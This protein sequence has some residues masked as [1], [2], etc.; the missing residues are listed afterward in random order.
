[1]TDEVLNL[2]E[3]KPTRAEILAKAR[4]AKAAK[5]IENPNPVSKVPVT[6][7]LE[8]ELWCRAYAYALLSCGINHPKYTNLAVAIADQ[9]VVDFKTKF[10]VKS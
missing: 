2:Q 9:A 8:Q 6:N 10:G 5:A 3:N 7:N 4:A 1:M